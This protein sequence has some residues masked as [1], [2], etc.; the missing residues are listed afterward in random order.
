MIVKEY[1]TKQPF[2]IINFLK[3]K[4]VWIKPVGDKWG[5]FK[6]TYWESFWDDINNSGLR[7]AI[8]NIVW[9]WKYRGATSVHK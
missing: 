9:L 3:R 2:P 7:I 8:Q 1:V 6:M 5:V 4:A